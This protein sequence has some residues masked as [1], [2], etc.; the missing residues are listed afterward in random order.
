VLVQLYKFPKPTLNTETQ[1]EWT[2]ASVTSPVRYR[3]IENL[4]ACAAVPP[5]Q[6]SDGHCKGRTRDD[7]YAE[8]SYMGL[9]G[10]SKRNDI[11][12]TSLHYII[13]I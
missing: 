7:G 10:G 2:S 1:A 5:D 4:V 13:L 12:R 3:I 9:I 8:I 11:I 6:T